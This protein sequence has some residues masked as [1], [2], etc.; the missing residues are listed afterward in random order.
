MFL[1]SRFDAGR[2]L[3]ARIEPLIDSFGGKERVAIAQ[4][5]HL[6]AVWARMDG[7]VS[8]SVRLNEIAMAEYEVLGAL[9]QKLFVANNL[10]DC[11]QQIG[12]YERT[13]E[14]LRSV[15]PVA[16]KMALDRETSLA[17]LNLSVAL[18]QLGRHAEALACADNA[19]RLY[20]A[21]G[22]RRY[23]GATLTF[24]ASA[25]AGD[26]RLD[27][28]AES[29]REAVAVLAQF[30]S[31]LPHA[32][33]VLADIELRS[34]RVDEALRL[35]QEAMTG[36][37]SLGTIL[38]GAELIRLTHARALHRAGAIADA[39]LA[40]AD[41]RDVILRSAARIGDPTLRD[42]FLKRVQA[43]AD[44]LRLAAEWLP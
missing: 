1:L 11:L 4:F 32:L 18:S 17:N 7:D 40:I 9:R 10:A 30:P 41:A 25:L 20:T 37:A 3:F 27:L 16:E 36:L 38:D 21:A 44:T 31:F 33:G 2:R 43:N 14:V 42:S 12:A 22:N 28:A 34:G 19:V 15:L 8:T 6:R 26:G 23:L 5:A 13:I 29:A 35:S 24:R 39:K